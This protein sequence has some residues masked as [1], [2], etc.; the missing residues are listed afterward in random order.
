MAEKYPELTEQNG[1]VETHEGDITEDNI[2]E[3]MSNEYLDGKGG[4]D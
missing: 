1:L 2:T 3:D 4:E